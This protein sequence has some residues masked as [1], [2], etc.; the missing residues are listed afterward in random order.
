[1]EKLFN[2][3]SGGVA[4]DWD[5]TKIPI[6]MLEE[7]YNGRIINK[8]GKGWVV[9]EVAGNKMLFQSEDGGKEIGKVEY[10]GITFY[11]FHSTA[12]GRG[13]IGSY[14]KPNLSTPG[15]TAAYGALQNLTGGP[16]APKMI[17]D[18]LTF[19]LIT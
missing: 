18:K 17:T 2:D 7:L 8:H 4:Y 11:F 13:E 9:T 10:K 15:F 1:M 16:F 12:T 5:R 6:N 3:L 14:P 19:L